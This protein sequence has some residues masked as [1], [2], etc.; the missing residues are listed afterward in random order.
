MRREPALTPDAQADVLHAVER[1][2]AQRANL[3]LEFLEEFERSTSM[4]RD[5]NP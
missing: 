1:Y 2:E 4:I 5:S 3:G